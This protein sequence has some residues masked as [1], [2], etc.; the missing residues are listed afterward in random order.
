MRFAKKLFNKIKNSF[1]RDI[2]A[3]LD[4]LQ[5]LH[6][7]ELSYR[8][9]NL[10]ESKM[11]GGK[12]CIEDGEF[13]VYS[14]NG[15]D[16][17]I[18]FLLHLL[19]SSLE[20][21]PK[22]FIEF[23]VENYRESNTRFL[24]CYRNF[25]GLVLYGLIDNIDF[26]KRDSIYWKYDLEACHAFI[27]KDNIND[28]IKSYLESR[29]LSNVVLLS[30][31]I[32]G[33]DFYI[34][35]SINVIDPAIVV[36]EYNALFGSTKCLSIPYKEDF[37]RFDAHYSGLYFGASIKALINLGESKGYRFVGADSSGTNLFFI[38]N[39]L[40]SSTL[41]IHSLDEYCKRHK[42]RQSRD[43]NGNLTYLAHNDRLKAIEG[44]PLINPF[45]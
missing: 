41:K 9:K 16:G 40:D 11:G 31:D 1:N 37:Y 4:T 28:L 33:N 26:I 22:A 10:I 44:L 34:W 7:S 5:L 2:D 30:I 35:E 27:T 36:I 18:D 38:K 29:D 13:K 23:G 39:H 20:S 6:G 19:D 24:L 42:A 12:H 3:R 25:C 43:K 17:I 45:S 8:N 32:D 15:E 14:Q 21:Y